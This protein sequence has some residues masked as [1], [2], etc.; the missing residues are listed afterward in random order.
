MAP[1]ELP[2]SFHF[3]LRLNSWLKTTTGNNA[4]IFQ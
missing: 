3:E 1:T 4:W 2:V